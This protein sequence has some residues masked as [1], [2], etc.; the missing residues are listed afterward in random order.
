MTLPIVNTTG[1][2][3]HDKDGPNSMVWYAR[4]EDGHPVWTVIVPTTSSV[5]AAPSAV[6][7]ANRF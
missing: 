7:V 6:N 1:S 3:K 4:N 5:V 2:A